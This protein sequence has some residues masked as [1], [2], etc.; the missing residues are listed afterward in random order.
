MQTIPQFF[1]PKVRPRYMDVSSSDF[2]YLDTNKVGRSWLAMPIQMILFRWTSPFP[3]ARRKRC[4]RVLWH[5]ILNV[6]SRKKVKSPLLRFHFF[7]GLSL[8]ALA[9]DL[10]ISQ[11]RISS[12]TSSSEWHR[13]RFFGPHC[14]IFGRAK[15]LPRSS[16]S[17]QLNVRV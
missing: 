3:R 8:I 5:L 16:Q 7:F 9:G 10:K 13:T 4:V 1:K 2:V 12:C 14:K 17:G 15:M 6:G 11:Q